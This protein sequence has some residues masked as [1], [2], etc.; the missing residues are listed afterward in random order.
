MN[1]SIFWFRKDLRLADHP[2]LVEAI[3]NSE[4]IYCIA[5]ADQIG[6][7]FDALSEIRKNSLR[8]SW[9]HLSASLD[10]RLTVIKSPA[11]IVSIAQKFNVNRI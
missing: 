1:T 2:A 8:S 3:E 7:P 4:V 9:S 6:S 10:G 11:E 5:S